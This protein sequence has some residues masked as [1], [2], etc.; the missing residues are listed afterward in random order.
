[1]WVTVNYTAGFKGSS[2]NRVVIIATGWMIHG[3]IPGRDK[4]GFISSTFRPD[5]KPAPSPSPYVPEVSSSGINLTTD[6][7]LVL[8]LKMS[9]PLPPFP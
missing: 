8:R 2:G 5:M 7:C 3:S 6:T 1:M 4:N 9:G